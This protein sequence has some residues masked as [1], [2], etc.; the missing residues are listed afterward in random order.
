MAQPAQKAKFETGNTNRVRGPNL[1][2]L[3]KRADGASFRRALELA[4]QGSL[5]LASNKRMS[6]ALVET[7]E[8]KSM[9]G[10][11]A[12]W[13]GTMTGYKEPGKKLGKFI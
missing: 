10:A 1:R 7:D 6:K 5:V 13:S 2:V 3:V 8:W 9:R 12:C 11:F 4:D